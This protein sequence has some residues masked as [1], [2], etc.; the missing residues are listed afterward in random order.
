MDTGCGREG[1][2]DLVKKKEEEETDTSQ[3]LFE[4][5]LEM[6]E[7]LK[8]PAVSGPRVPSESIAEAK[9]GA[10]LGLSVNAVAVLMFFLT[11]LTF[12]AVAGPHEVVCQGG[13]VNY[14][15]QKPD[16]Q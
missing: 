12:C 11:S 4:Y 10:K 16:H 6:R 14:K 1:V 5:E 9:L 13:P 8:Q 7:H 3:M 15:I 2:L